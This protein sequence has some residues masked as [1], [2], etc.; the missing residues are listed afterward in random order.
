MW[1]DWRGRRGR[2]C[3]PG[4][5]W[6]EID[7]VDL[8]QAAAALAEREDAK[9]LSGAEILRLGIGIDGS[10]LRGG[11]DVQGHSWATDIVRRAST[12]STSPVTRPEGF[13]GELRQYQAEALTW[14]GFLDA[15][16]L[17]G[18]LALDMGLGKTP[19]VLAQLARTT[20]SGTALVIAPAAVVGNWAAEAARFVPGLR[21][22]VHHG[23]SRSAAAQLET[24]IAEADV[25][26]TTYATAVRD[27]DALA[28]VSWGTMVLDE[29]QAIKNPVSD[30]AQ[31]LR[32]I[33]ARTR[34]ALDGHTDR[35]R[36][37]RPVGHLGLHQSGPRRCA[38]VVRRPAVRQ[39]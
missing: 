29:A 22:V 18:C 25:V 1:R 16:G 27:I 7:R 31:Q 23:A 6:V 10:G 5:G 37:R 39:R 13:V 11:V 28:A 35:E 9:Q 30:T 2:S 32:R 26:I 34:L 19:T 38:S 24:E 12:A 4:A 36:A 15:A 20:D 8:E 33:P 17:G 21:V 3:S 14:I